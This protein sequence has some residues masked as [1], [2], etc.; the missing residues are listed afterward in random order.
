MRPSEVRGGGGVGL[1]GD[2]Y[3]SLG[4]V[5]YVVA[6]VTLNSA[7]HYWGKSF[8]FYFYFSLQQIYADEQ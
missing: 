6:D 3:L 5:L 4:D 7:T 2:R 8:Y 1:K